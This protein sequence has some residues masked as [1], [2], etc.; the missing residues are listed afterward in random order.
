MEKRGI[1]PAGPAALLMA[2]LLVAGSGIFPGK[3]PAPLPDLPAAGMASLLEPA[4]SA[5]SFWAEAP[6]LMPPHSEEAQ[7]PLPREEA[8]LYTG[9]S[10]GGSPDGAVYFKNQTDYDIDMSALLAQA[11]AVKLGDQGVQ[12]LIMHTHGTEAYTPSEGHTYQATGDYRTT[13]RDCNMLAVGRRVAELL[14]QRGIETVHSETLNDYP[15]YN[16]SYTRALK[17]INAWLERYPSVNL[18]IDLH[19]DAIGTAGHYYKTA[20]QVDGQQTA[21]LMFVTGTDQGGL[22][23]PNWRQNLSFQAQLHQRLNSRYPGIMRPMSIRKGRF[24]QHARTG[25]MLVEV[26]ACGN[27]LE[28]ALAAAEVFAGTLADFLLD[29]E[30]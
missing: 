6:L 27:T 5:Q 30:N 1:P 16:G 22:Q 20:A 19:R 26:G 9:D 25:S 21:Q 18:V 29:G 12:V 4:E 15:A 3:K 28:E 23:H 14:N 13:D 11:P 8:P 7:A 2:A 17:D 10:A 24:N